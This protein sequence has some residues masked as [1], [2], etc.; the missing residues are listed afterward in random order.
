[1]PTQDEHDRPENLVQPADLPVKPARSLQEE[2][3]SNNSLEGY[4]AMN[5]LNNDEFGE[6]AERLEREREI[7]AQKGNNG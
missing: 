2:A 5:N 6:E 3:N 7:A 4:A 1:M